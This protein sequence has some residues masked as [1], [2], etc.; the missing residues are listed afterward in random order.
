MSFKHDYLALEALN[1]LKIK[2]M[3]NMFLFISPVKMTA[4]AE[5]KKVL[6]SEYL[7]SSVPGLSKGLFCRMTRECH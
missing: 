2:A 3:T 4:P 7:L 6:M 5:I 1:S